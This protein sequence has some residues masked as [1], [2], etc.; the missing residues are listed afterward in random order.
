MLIIKRWLWIQKLKRRWK[1][2]NKLRRSARDKGWHGI[3]EVFHCERSYK[4]IREEST[5]MG[6]NEEDN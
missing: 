5:R 1:D 2:G 6:L 4:E 3:L